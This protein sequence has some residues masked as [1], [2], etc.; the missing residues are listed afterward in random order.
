MTPIADC[1]RI[2]N[3]FECFSEIAFGL[4]DSPGQAAPSV[5]EQVFDD[6]TEQLGVAAA[7]TRPLTTD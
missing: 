3:L 1:A 7:D 2:L 5:I 4:M 6:R